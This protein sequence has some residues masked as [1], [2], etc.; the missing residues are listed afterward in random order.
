MTVPEP[1]RSPGPGPT[2]VAFDD[3]VDL[4]GPL[5]RYVASLVR[6]PHDVDDVVQETLI[7]MWQAT[8]RLEVRNVE[9]VRVH[10]GSQP[11]PG[12]GQV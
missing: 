3:L 9:R 1:T 4:S 2:S 12:P 5:R 10:R 7:R 11:G 6:D 8:Q